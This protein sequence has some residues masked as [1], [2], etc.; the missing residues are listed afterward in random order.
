MYSQV[1]ASSLNELSVAPV[2]PE[3]TIFVPKELIIADVLLFSGINIITA[4]L[5]RWEGCNTSQ[6]DNNL[7]GP[8]S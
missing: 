5:T 1:A 4:V 7:G 2:A 8:P 6:Y 3:T